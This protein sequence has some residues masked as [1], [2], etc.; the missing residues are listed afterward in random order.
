MGEGDMRSRYALNLS[1]LYERVGT[2]CERSGRD[3]AS[4]EIL[5]ATKTRTP[6]QIRCAVDEMRVPLIGENAVQEVVIKASALQDL[7]AMRHFIGTLQKNKVK[8]L[9]D[10]VNQISCIHSVDKLSLAKEIHRRHEQMQIPKPL[11]ILIQVNTSKEDSKG[12]CPSAQAVDLVK[13]I[14]SLYG[15]RVSIQGLMTIS[16]VGGDDTA[17]RECFRQL[18]LLRAEVESLSLPGVSMGVM[19]YGMTG[20][21]EVAIEEGSTLI[22]LGTMIFGE[23]NYPKQQAPELPAMEPPPVP[24]GCPSAS[25]GTV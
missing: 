22:R 10:P 21:F 7:P 24:P 3:P 9:L 4:V 2:A 14:A 5:L 1:K 16:A 11:G 13:D 20:D 23:R 12:G 15:D 17:T 19:S 25:T 8:A 18:Q 6:E